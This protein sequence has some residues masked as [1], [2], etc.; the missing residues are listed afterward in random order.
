MTKEMLFGREPEIK[1]L[2]NLWDS[3]EA[4]FLA[5]YGRRRVGKTYLIREYFSKKRCIYFEITG[6]KD[7]KLKEQLENFINIFSKVFL[8]DL[9][10]R[11]PSSWKNAFEI[12]TKEIEKIPKSQNIVF[13]F[14]ELPWLATSKSGMLQ[15][16]DYY[17]NRFWSRHSNLIFVVCGSAASWMLDNLINAKGGLHNRLTKTILLRPYNLKQTEQYLAGRNIHLSPKQILDLYMVFGGIPHYLKQVE[18]GKSALQTINKVCFQPDGLL[19]DEFD[20]LFRSLFSYAEESLLI[21]KAISKYQYGISRDDLIKSTG[22]SSGGTLNKRL[23]ELESAGFIQ[24]YVPYG[25]KIKNH[26][27]RV[28]DEYCYFYLR[29]IEPFKKKGMSAGKEY[30]QT[31]GKTGTAITWAGYA[32]ES[33]CLKHIDQIRKALELEAISCEIGNW[34]FSPPKGKKES[35]AQ[36]DL[37]FDREDGIVSLCEIKYTEKPFILDKTEAKNLMNKVAVFEDHFPIK[38]QILLTLITAA[39]LKENIWSEELIQ[40]VVTLEDLLQF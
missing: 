36:I 28:V 22:I 26:Y 12:L 6:Q 7:G 33:I 3:P 38:K 34:K 18:K 23:K 1:I 40:N 27:Y 11:T 16:L 30:W 15:A 10:L 19:Y 25:R 37:L 9:P 35:G 39:G 24:S 13:F 32:F 14:D 2:D 31:K 8:N 20:R 4:E 17:W 29:W 21:I 5:I